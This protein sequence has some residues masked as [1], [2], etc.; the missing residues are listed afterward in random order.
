MFTDFATRITGWSRRGKWIVACSASVLASTALAGPLEKAWIDRDARWVIHLDVEGALASSLGPLM[1]DSCRTADHEVV[2]FLSDAGVD[3]GRDLK[4]LTVYAF[5]AEPKDAVAIINATPAIDG[6]AERLSLQVPGFERIA[7]KPHPQY[8]WHEDG[9]KRYGQ[10]LPGPAGSRL[11]LVARD[12]VLLAAAAAVVAGVAPNLDSVET[13]PLA[14]LPQAGSFIFAMARVEGLDR[15]GR[16]ALVTRM[17]ESF[18]FEAGEDQ[19]EAYATLTLTTREERDAKS[20][21]QILNGMLA[22]A[23]LAVGDDPEQAELAGM[24]DMVEIA[25]DGSQ[26]SARISM[27]SERMRDLVK[28]A[29]RAGRSW[30]EDREDKGGEDGEQRP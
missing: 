18:V 12:P 20:M 16:V 19:A 27:A 28:E 23:R 26:V 2:A 9:V 24:L 5:G 11:A 17:T 10:I 6:L 25:G 30:R 7:D 29:T 15:G 14:A 8:T 13:G 4:G 22:M 21:V 1:T 3:P